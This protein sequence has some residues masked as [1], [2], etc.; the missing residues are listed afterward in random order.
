MW[1]CNLDQAVRWADRRVTLMPSYIP[2]TLLKPF[3]LLLIKNVCFSTVR[4]TF[5]HTDEFR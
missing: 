5:Q 3:L 2:D 4:V 1:G